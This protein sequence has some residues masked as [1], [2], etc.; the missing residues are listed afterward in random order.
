M[1]EPLRL[2]DE[3]VNRGDEN[4]PDGLGITLSRDLEERGAFFVLGRSLLVPADVMKRG[5]LAPQHC[6]S[7]AFPQGRVKKL[8]PMLAHASFRDEL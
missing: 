4:A 6:I 3:V 7:W 8:E 1:N 5:Q 2:S